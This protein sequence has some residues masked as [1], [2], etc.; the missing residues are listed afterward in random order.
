MTKYSFD[1][2]RHPD[3]AR[4]LAQLPPDS[5]QKIFHLGQLC[6][7]SNAVSRAAFDKYRSLVDQTLWQKEKLARVKQQIGVAKTEEAL[8]KVTAAQ[9]AINDAEAA[10]RAQNQIVEEKTATWQTASGVFTKVSKWLSDNAGSGFAACPVEIDRRQLAKPGEG[11]GKQREAVAQLKAELRRVQA[12]PLPSSTAKDLARRQ[13][14]ELAKRARPNVAELVE[15]GGAI[16]WPNYHESFSTLGIDTAT[17]GAIPLPNVNGLLAW[18]MPDALAA[19]L[20]AE[21]DAVADDTAA[22]EPAQRETREARL[23]DEILEA[24][25]VEE[26]L[27]VACEA[28]GIVAERRPDASPLAILAVSIEVQE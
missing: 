15:A 22:M 8:E 5:Q 18:L 23:L 13:L 16:R 6:D 4:L 10:E 1:D 11:L 14:A 19:A 25:R 12:A 17:R 28:A 24:E 26:A 9:K 7:D 3:R 20:D 21:I 2:P 27:I